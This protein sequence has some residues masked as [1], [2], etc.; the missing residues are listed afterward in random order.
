LDKTVSGTTRMVVAV[1]RAE[2]KKVRAVIGRKKIVFNIRRAAAVL[3]G[4]RA[5]PTLSADGAGLRLEPLVCGAA[6]GACT[7]ACRARDVSRSV[8]PDAYC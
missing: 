2:E 5:P 3:C 7:A 8:L 1:F 6:R 4:W